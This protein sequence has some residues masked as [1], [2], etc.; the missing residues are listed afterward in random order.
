MNWHPDRFTALL[1]S[2]VLIEPVRRNMLLSLAEA[3]L[4][5]PRWSVHILKQTQDG[6]ENEINDHEKSVKHR[7]SIDF[8]F[9]EGTVTGFEDIEIGL[10]L[11]NQSDNHVL[12][13]A[14]ATYAS[15]IVT[16]NPKNFPSK[17]HTF[18]NIEAMS[19]DSF[20]ANSVELVPL[21][22]LNALRRMRLRFGRPSMNADKFI[23]TISSRN[24]T[25]TA[26]I[27][28]KY[29]RSL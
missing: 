27:L 10:K 21:V 23:D 26:T 20:I 9:K 28:S 24:L 1:D 16:E 29:K 12:A 19:A 8:A 22:S 6:I 11:P 3:E 5:R 15:V 7:E 25:E 17:F 2:S 14:I 18:K 13:A 4:F